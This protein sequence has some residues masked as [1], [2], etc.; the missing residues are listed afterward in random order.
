MVS[1]NG[2][3]YLW[4]VV[5]VWQDDNLNQVC[6]KSL[7]VATLITGVDLLR[8]LHRAIIA[9]VGKLLPV[10]LV[11]IFD[12]FIAGVFEHCVQFPGSN[13]VSFCSL[14]MLA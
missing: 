12:A 1:L 4:F 7:T 6:I 5:F 8:T 11:P 13:I 2:D 10:S 14:N 3:M 9:F